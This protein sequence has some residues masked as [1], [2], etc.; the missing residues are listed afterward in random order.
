MHF[1]LCVI[2]NCDFDV[3]RDSH[4]N[5]ELSVGIEGYLSE[6]SGFGGVI[7]Q[8]WED[9]HV[10]EVSPEGEILHLTELLSASELSRNIEARESLERGEG[11]SMSL[12]FC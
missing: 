5:A 1:F 10:H 7:K 8:R 12:P 9:F 4:V 3:E 6:H 11:A 2:M